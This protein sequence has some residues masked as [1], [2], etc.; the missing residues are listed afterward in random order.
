MFCCILS[1]SCFLISCNTGNSDTKYDSTIGIVHTSQ[2]M[3]KSRIDWYNDELELLGSS[4]LTYA[5]LG[6]HFYKPLTV[7]NEVYM[8]PQGL[9]NN[10]STKKVI[11]LNKNTFEISEYPFSNI[12]LNHMAV[13]NKYVYAVNTMNG[14]SYIERYDKESHKN[15]IKEYKETYIY[16]IFPMSE[17]LLAFSITADK[18]LD[19][20]TLRVM[21]KDLNIVK[22][23]SLTKFGRT[24]EM[25]CEDDSYMYFTMQISTDDKPISK[26]LSIDKR[27]Y[28]IKVIDIQAEQPSDIFKYEDKFLITNYN[29]VEVKGTKVSVVGEEGRLYKDIELNNELSL[30][31]IYGKYLVVANLQKL[32][33]YDINTFELKREVKLDIDSES[34]VSAI[35]IR[36]N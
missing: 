2:Q 12:A 1:I 13:I 4:K 11:S 32:S 10:K 33:L 31:Q 19:S 8:I 15:I 21:D 3:Y 28:D 18:G 17:K 9:G 26:I 5:G 14:S 36:G 35:I 23:I 27:N 7:D 6:S 34:Y 16:G 29:P 20:C 24:T 22:E 30:T 25:Y